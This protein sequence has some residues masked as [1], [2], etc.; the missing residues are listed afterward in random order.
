MKSLRGKAHKKQRESQKT[1]LL[2]SEKEKKKWTTHITIVQA[3]Y[4]HNHLTHEQE[5]RLMNPR[6]TTLYLT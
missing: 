2:E 4:H 3:R 1:A 5:F 6:N